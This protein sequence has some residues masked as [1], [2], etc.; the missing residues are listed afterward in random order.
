MVFYFNDTATTEIYTYGHT[1]SLHVAL[2][3]SVTAR[4]KPGRTVLLSERRERP[5][6]STMRR[7]RARRR[8]EEH[9]YE[10]QVTNA[11]I[12]CRLLLEINKYAPH[13]TKIND[14]YLK[15]SNHEYSTQ[16]TTE[17]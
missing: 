2:P 9:T 17:Y 7:E 11:P 15:I 16:I 3:I 4:P 6:A 12:V 5:P 8:S 1:L 10:L 13:T 14:T